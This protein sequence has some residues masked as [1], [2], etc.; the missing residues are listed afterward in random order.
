MEI[1]KYDPRIWNRTIYG[2]DQFVEKPG[3]RIL[4]YLQ[5]GPDR[6]VVQVKLMHIPKDTKV[7]PTRVSKWKQ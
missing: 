2:L 1:K 7:P 5:D 4:Y 6:A 3:N